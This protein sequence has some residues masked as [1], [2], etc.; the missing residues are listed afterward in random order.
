PLD[1][2]IRA[3]GREIQSR[4]AAD[5]PAA[6]I[7]IR[8]IHSNIATTPGA[9]PTGV[10]VVYRFLAPEAIVAPPS[11]AQP[12]PAL[13]AHPA[14]IP[15]VQGQ[16][17]GPERPPE[18]LAPFEVA[19]PQ[20]VGVQPLRLS[21]RPGAAGPVTWPWGLS[22]YRFSILQSAGGAGVAGPVLTL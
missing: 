19:P 2:F 3:W 4:M 18:G 6:V 5:S 22:A 8:E 14:P 1:P 11:P 16:F 15:H 7:R 10:T 13:R 9:A 20:V 17:G 12:A 21:Q